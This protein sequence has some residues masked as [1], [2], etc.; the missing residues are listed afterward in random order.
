MKV[1]QIKKY[2]L[3]LECNCLYIPG[4]SERLNPNEAIDVES[5]RVCSQGIS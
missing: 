2:K 1:N 4:L 5:P 3:W